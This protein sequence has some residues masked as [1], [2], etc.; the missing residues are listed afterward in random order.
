MAHVSHQVALLAQA[1]ADVSAF[2]RDVRQSDFLA[3]VVG[4]EGP[5]DASSLWDLLQE[6][7]G[8]ATPQG[9]GDASAHWDSALSRRVAVL[10]DEECAHGDG[11]ALVVALQDGR[12]VG[13]LRVAR[14]GVLE[15]AR[16]LTQFVARCAPSHTYTP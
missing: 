2:V 7:P 1:G 14:S 11:S 5:L 9:A 15:V 16:I 3:E 10:V 12:V 8:P 6:C 4:G 13:E